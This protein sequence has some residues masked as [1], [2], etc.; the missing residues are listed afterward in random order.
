MAGSARDRET[1]VQKPKPNPAINQ[2]WNQRYGPGSS[3]LA[4]YQPGR[5]TPAKPPERDFAA[6]LGAWWQTQGPMP[7]GPQPP[8]NPG[9]GAMFGGGNG[10]GGRP[11]GTAAH[12]AAADKAF[13]LDESPYWHMQ[14]A[15]DNQGR[16]LAAYNPNFAGMEQTALAAGQRYQGERDAL[17]AQ[18][19]AGIPQMG[20]TLA[21]QQGTAIANAVRDLG[22]Q[23]FNAA[24]YVQQANEMGTARTGALNNMNQY[25]AML[26]MNNANAQQDWR[27]GLSTIRQGGETALANA[28]GVMQN[29]LAQQAAQIQLQAAQARQEMAQAKLQY[30]A[31]AGLI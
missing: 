5:T 26:N 17:M 7:G 21:G 15:L 30:M 31:Q 2:S 23:G 19:Q 28:R 10:G 12:R 3:S 13:T 8:T 20:A 22:G 1:Y 9:L 6:E 18:L 16:Q 29:D 25:L 27:Q 4:V 14:A 24:P 11:G